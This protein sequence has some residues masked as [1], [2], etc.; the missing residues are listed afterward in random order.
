MEENLMMS[1]NTFL[2]VKKADFLF[3]DKKIFGP[4]SFHFKSGKVYVVEGPSGQGK[5]TFM[6]T[7]S[8]HEVLNSGAIELQGQKVNRPSKEIFYVNQDGDLFDWL[9]VQGHFDLCEKLG[10]DAKTSI[11]MIQRFELSQHLNMY[12]FQLS[13]GMRKRLGLARAILM[14]P[15]VLILDETLSS[16]DQKMRFNVLDFI[17]NWVHQNNSLCII[18][19]HFS[20]ELQG[21]D[22]I[23]LSL[24]AKT[25]TALPADP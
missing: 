23:H 5:T 11:E 25:L 2:E 15:K 19:T 17:K 24:E 6:K 22:F 7:L 14:K 16:L 10:A 13:A 21:N 4:I 1:N 3:K 8:G 20:D 18:V 9:T 12:P